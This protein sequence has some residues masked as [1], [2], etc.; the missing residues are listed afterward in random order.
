MKKNYKFIIICI[1]IFIIGIY[2]G[3]NLFN[4]CDVNRDGKVSASD[5]VIVKDYIMNEGE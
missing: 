3:L 2:I 1:L 5:Y 4:P